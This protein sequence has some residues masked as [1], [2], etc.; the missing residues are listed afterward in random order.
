MVAILT[1]I[2]NLSSMWDFQERKIQTKT[3]LYKSLRPGYNQLKQSYFLDND[4][5]VGDTCDDTLAAEM[6][7][8]FTAIVFNDYIT[9]QAQGVI[10]PLAIGGKFAGG[11]FTINQA[12]ASNCINETNLAG[13]GLIVGTNFAGINT[14]VF[15]AAYLPAGSDTSQIEEETSGCLVYT[16]RSTGIYDFAM[17]KQNSVYASQQFSEETPSLQLDANGK[18]TR[19]GVADSRGYDIITFNTCSTAQT[20]TIPVLVNS[21]ITLA[22]NQLSLQVDP[23]NSIMNFYPSDA[24]GNYVEGGSFTIFRNTGGRVGGVILAPTADVVDS[25]TGSFAGQLV[26]NNYGWNDNG[27]FINDYAGAGGSC[28]YFSGC[29]PL[30]NVSVPGL[31]TRSSSSESSTATSI[32]TSSEISI[33]ASISTSSES[34]SSSESQS[35]SSSFSNESTSDNSSSSFSSTS[36]SSFSTDESTSITSSSSDASNDISSSSTDSSSS[37]DDITLSSSSSFSESS[38]STSSSSDGVFTRSSSSSA[39]PSSSGLSGFN[40]EGSSSFS[41][42]TSSSASFI[43]SFNISRALSSSISSLTINTNDT[44]L[45][46]MPTSTSQITSSKSSNSGNTSSQG[47]GPSTTS[48]EDSSTIIRFTSSIENI[49]LSV[50]SLHQEHVQRARFQKRRFYRHITH[51]HDDIEYRCDFRDYMPDRQDI[52]NEGWIDLCY[53]VFMSDQEPIVNIDILSNVFANDDFVLEKELLDRFRE[54]QMGLQNL[55]V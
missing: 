5:F 10:G 26:A 4:G 21:S 30:V 53:Q 11:S 12:H 7:N 35:S 22:G 14:H 47:S 44:K 27:V 15:G 6:M 50:P 28:S 17:V 40:S 38:G 19:I 9:K 16:N 18:L 29:F 48:I 25:S 54:I 3:N 36:L 24:N 8:R 37:F 32:S 39:V 20:C 41:S 45:S 43:Y 46:P 33:S 34:R 1:N 52:T 49:Y 31:S 2:K 42:S 23:C 55:V 13:Y 51:Y